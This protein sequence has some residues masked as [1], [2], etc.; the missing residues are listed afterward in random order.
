[1]CCPVVLSCTLPSQP[2]LTSHLFF[3]LFSLPT[4]YLS[5][6]IICVFFLSSP[7]PSLFDATC[8]TK[9][10]VLSCLPFL[11]RFPCSGPFLLS[12]LDSS[13]LV[14]TCLDPFL[15]WPYLAYL[16]FVAVALHG[17]STGLE[18]AG[19]VCVGPLFALL[20]WISHSSFLGL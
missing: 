15:F 16:A 20:V 2:V 8:I 17:S 5:R 9:T 13:C 18:V 1:M 7:F 4:L 10:F 6:L 14:L 12:G 19:F 11:V 3:G